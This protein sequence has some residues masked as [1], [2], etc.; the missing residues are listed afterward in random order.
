METGPYNQLIVEHQRALSIKLSYI[1]IIIIHG[2]PIKMITWM[3]INTIIL[4]V[5]VEYIPIRLNSNMS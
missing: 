4:T 2:G 1:R 5:A 3:I